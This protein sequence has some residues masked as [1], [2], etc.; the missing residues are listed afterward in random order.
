MCV[1]NFDGII[2][3]CEIELSLLRLEFSPGE[4]GE[5]HDV[6]SG[7]S[8]QLRIGFPAFSGPLFGVVIDTEIEL[9]HSIPARLKRNRRSARGGA[10]ER[11]QYLR[12]EHSGLEECCVGL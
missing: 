11:H 9:R 7:L 1:Q 5:A 12:I 10:V 4:F 2:E 6:E 8:H 3:P